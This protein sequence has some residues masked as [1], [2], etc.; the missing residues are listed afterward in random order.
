[1]GRVSRCRRDAPQTP[2]VTSAR[3]RTH[4]SGDE[5]R[6]FHA[7]AVSVQRSVPAIREREAAAGIFA[8]DLGGAGPA[9]GALGGAAVGAADAS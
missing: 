3:A 9:A 1:M 2:R 7:E 8:G 5:R 4:R 6:R